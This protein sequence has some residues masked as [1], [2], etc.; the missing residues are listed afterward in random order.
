MQDDS[1][2]VCAQAGS[3][4]FATSVAEAGEA[5]IPAHMG[6]GGF[7]AGGGRVG[8]HG[9]GPASSAELPLGSLSG[10]A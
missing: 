9:N 6:R 4:A 8:I 7:A 3:H 2:P 5:L 10:L 1:R